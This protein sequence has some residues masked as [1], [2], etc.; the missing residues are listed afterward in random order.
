MK[1]IISAFILAGE[2]W[3][4]NA[5]QQYVANLIKGKVLIG[6]SL[7]NDLSG[8]LCHKRTKQSII[9]LIVLGIPHPAVSTRDVALYQV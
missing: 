4:F 2:A 8:V 3:S 7:W 1:L 9:M 6:H 5:V